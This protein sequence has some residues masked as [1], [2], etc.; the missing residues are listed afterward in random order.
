MNEIT[1]SMPNYGERCCSLLQ[2]TYLQKF[3]YCVRY[4]LRLCLLLLP[5]LIYSCKL[6]VG[7]FWKLM[8]LVCGCVRVPRPFGMIQV[9]FVDFPNAKVLRY[10]CSTMVELPSLHMSQSSIGVQR[11]DLYMVKGHLR[12]H[13]H[14][15]Q[16]HLRLLL[17]LFEL[18]IFCDRVAHKSADLTQGNLVYSVC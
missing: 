13:Q 5:T 17:N 14:Y 7:E 15:H 8:K 3:V 12:F 16:G 2:K 11:G 4:F 6:L 1:N 18:Y 10:G 9:L